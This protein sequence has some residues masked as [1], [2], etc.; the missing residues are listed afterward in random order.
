M[1]NNT[2]NDLTHGSVVALLARVAKLESEV[3]VLTTEREELRAELEEFK[4]LEG[5]TVLVSCADLKSMQMKIKDLEYDLEI[6]IDSRAEL[7]KEFKNLKAKIEGGVRVVA[8]RHPSGWI[9]FMEYEE[10]SPNGTLI[11]DDGVDL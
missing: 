3:T 11:L 6:V 8:K 5:R 2:K 9:G 7:H 1:M 10:E 4:K